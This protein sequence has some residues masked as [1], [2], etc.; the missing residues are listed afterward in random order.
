MLIN[1]LVLLIAFSG[2]FAGYI[3]ALI[4]PEELE[5]GKKHFMVFQNIAFSLFGLTAVYFFY[6][7]YVLPIIVAIVIFGLSYLFNITKLFY[8]PASILFFFIDKND[9]L[10][11]AGLMFFLTGMGAASYEATI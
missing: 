6:P 3:L 8:L 4:A 1:F 2:I 10:L 7:G 5:P 11:I 9:I